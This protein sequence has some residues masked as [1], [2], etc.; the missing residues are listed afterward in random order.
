MLTPL[1]EKVWEASD[2]LVRVHGAG[3]VK[4]EC[5]LP[6][7]YAGQR[8]GI[9]FMPPDTEKSSSNVFS[10]TIPIKFWNAPEPPP[11]ELLFG[12]GWRASSLL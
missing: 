8:H 2:P 7:L 12:Q 10:T 5:P 3:A 11:W 1:L 4:A 6:P 9:S